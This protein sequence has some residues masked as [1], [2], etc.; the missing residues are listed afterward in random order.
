MCTQYQFFPSFPQH[1][2][3]EVHE[4]SKYVIISVPLQGDCRSVCWYLLVFTICHAKSSQIFASVPISVTGISFSTA[5]FY[6]SSIFLLNK[7]HLFINNTTSSCGCAHWQSSCPYFHTGE[8]TQTNAYAFL[9]SYNFLTA[10][11]HIFNHGFGNNSDEPVGISTWQV[12]S[13]E[14][15]HSN[16]YRALM[17]ATWRYALSKPI[18]RLAFGLLP[19]LNYPRT[20]LLH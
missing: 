10:V 1:E 6:G 20:L 5:L 3:K 4:H 18:Q 11:S 17:Y 15:V 8:T 9:H 14:T 12:S 19:S 16:M 7:Y 2:E 13:I